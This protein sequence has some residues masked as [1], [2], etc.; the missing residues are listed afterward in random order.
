MPANGED[1]QAALRHG[2]GVAQESEAA[3]RPATETSNS[4]S[5]SIDELDL[6]NFDK[7]KKR[8]GPP[9]GWWA[10]LRGVV[11]TVRDVDVLFAK[12]EA[13]RNTC[14]FLVG[15]V[16][17]WLAVTVVAVV[18]S[19]FEYTPLFFLSIAEYDAGQIDV[20]VS[21]GAWTRHRF[22]NFSKFMAEIGEEEE[23]LSYAAPRIELPASLWPSKACE[24]KL[25][26]SDVRERYEGPTPGEPC[27]GAAH[28][29]S[30]GCLARFCGPSSSAWL[31]L[32]DHALE[33]RMGLGRHWPHGPV[34]GGEIM[35]SRELAQRLGVA[36]GDPL[37]LLLDLQHL[38]RAAVSAHTI[39]EMDAATSALLSSFYVPLTVAAV[40]NSTHGRLDEEETAGAF[41][42]LS[43][44]IASLPL[45][46]NPQAGAIAADLEGVS[47]F[48][49]AETINFNLPQPRLQSYM[50]NDFQEV[51]GA[52][53]VF[54]SRVVAALGP[55]NVRAEVLLLGALQ[56]LRVLSLFL[57]LITSVIMSGLSGL[58]C[59]LIYPLHPLR[60]LHGPPRPPPQRGA[61]DQ[62][63]PVCHTLRRPRRQPQ[64]RPGGGG[65]DRACRR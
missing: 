5:K 7:L 49:F 59:L 41:V 21:A 45:H 55:E 57:A 62:E 51:K 15:L 65:L 58:L 48:D 61:A 12:R 28:V 20:R 8:S 40:L 22:L 13:T 27:A 56:Q 38:V 10:W 50:S 31:V 19:G 35:I 4:Q 25:N 37:T 1:D 2:D 24:G 43:S 47:A 29:P 30:E 46:A 23:Y 53:L 14:T 26:V 17:C 18:H 52:V 11:L 36:P 32:H 6:Q 34:K 63:G 54:A 33:E 60:L 3:E 42:D 64:P 44:F 39:L 9:P 16:A